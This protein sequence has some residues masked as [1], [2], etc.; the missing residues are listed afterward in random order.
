MGQS[1][2]ASALE[3]HVW[4]SEQRY[5]PDVLHLPQKL[6]DSTHSPVGH[7]ENSPRQASA[8]T[9]AAAKDTTI[10]AGKS[11]AA[12]MAGYCA[13]FSFQDYKPQNGASNAAC[14]MHRLLGLLVLYRSRGPPRRRLSPLSCAPP[15]MHTPRADPGLSFTS[16]RGDGVHTHVPGVATILSVLWKAQGGSPGCF[17]ADD[18][19]VLACTGREAYA[20][21]GR[22]HHARH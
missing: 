17:G 1:F 18:K 10:A 2:T 13:Y 11:N 9:A 7:A 22:S 15:P 3:T 5:S 4:P 14:S 12:G 21:G 6:G 8:V 16:P 20:V 19:V